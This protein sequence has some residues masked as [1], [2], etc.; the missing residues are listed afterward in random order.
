[1]ARGGFGLRGI[2]VG[3]I[4]AAIIGILQAVFTVDQVKGVGRGRF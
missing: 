2:L 3:C 1:M 4:V